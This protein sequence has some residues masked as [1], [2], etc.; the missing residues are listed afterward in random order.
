[1]TPDKSAARWCGAIALALALCAGP[2]AF[3]MAQGGTATRADVERLISIALVTDWVVRECGA[4]GLA[5]ML[6]AT[7]PSVLKQLTPEALATGRKR[8][9]A[10]ATSYKSKDAA[11]RV[12]KGQLIAIQ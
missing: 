5:G 11:C 2:A 4:E 6:V 1:M 7:M 3:Q 8:V 9:E 10:R 12:L